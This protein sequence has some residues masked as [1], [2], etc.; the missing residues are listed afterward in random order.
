M[1]MEKHIVKIDSINKINHDVLRVVTERPDEYYFTPGQATDISVN[2]EGWKEEKK[3]FTFTSLPDD[4]YLEFHI[5]TYPER[6]RVTNE[7]LKLHKGDELILHSVFGAITYKKEGVFIAGGA[8]VTPFIAILRQLHS[9]DEMGENKLIFANK[10]KEDIFLKEEFVE[11]LGDN[12]VNILSDEETD[13][14]AHGFVT[15]DFLQSQIE[16]T[17]KNFYICGPPPMLD[18]LEEILAEL[19]MDKDSIVK[20]EF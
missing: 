9:N 7:L 17:H 16:N 5:K 19:D 13:E 8:G 2:K 10:T 15:K 4:D 18:M 1:V 6:E 3:P 12:F 20:E 11:M 14:Y